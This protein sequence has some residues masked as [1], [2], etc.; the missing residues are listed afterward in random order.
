MSTV[1]ENL[2]IGALA[3]WL[4]ATVL[5][6]LP[7]RTWQQLR[8]RMNFLGLLPY[9]GFFTSRLSTKDY[10]LCWRPVVLGAAAGDW[11]EI[12]PHGRRPP[13]SALW[14]PDRRV[15]KALLDLSITLIV[16]QAGEHLELSVLRT[17]PLYQALQ[18]FCRGRARVAGAA[19]FQFA[20]LASHGRD[21]E[22]P[23]SV[24]FIS[25]RHET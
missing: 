16:G 24:Y 2:V 12:G 21:S 8:R 6:Q 4:V 20:V 17:S 25:D 9:W 10:H 5:G 11:Q 18:E 1:G 23:W 19:A 7:G 15:R 3:L 14:H 22:R 13:G